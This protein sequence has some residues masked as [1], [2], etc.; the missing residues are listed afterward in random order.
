[1]G[2]DVLYEEIR[3]KLIADFAAIPPNMVWSADKDHLYTLS[4]LQV[5]WSEMHNGEL[6][7]TPEIKAEIDA[8]RTADTMKG[9]QCNYGRR[10]TAVTK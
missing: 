7:L 5:K 1:M 3:A 4:Q 6:F 8:Y 2:Q 9:R 10:K